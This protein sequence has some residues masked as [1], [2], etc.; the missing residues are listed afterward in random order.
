MSK[1][2]FVSKDISILIADDHASTRDLIKAILRSTGFNRVHQA[3][4]GKMLLDCLIK[5]KVNL[6]ICDWNMPVLNGLE[7]LKCVR[8]DSRYKDIPFIMLT[9]E[10]Y[11]DSLKAA[12]AAGVSDYI[13]KP[14]TA[15][16]LLNK[17]AHVF[18]KL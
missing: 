3:E 2:D 1:I 18:S 9:A 12:I 11:G 17:I 16:T 5:E 7:T 14:F 10:A 13:A 8:E 4:N 6:I 15:E